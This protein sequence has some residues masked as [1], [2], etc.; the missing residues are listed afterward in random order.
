MKTLIL[1]VVC[2]FLVSCGGGTT[3]LL[4][5]GTRLNWDGSVASS[6]IRVRVF[7]LRSGAAL[8]AA[9]P[10]LIDGDARAI[11]G[12]D[13]VGEPKEVELSAP[14][15]TERE[16]GYRVRFQEGDLHPET[17]VIGVVGCFTSPTDDKWKATLKVEALNDYYF[18]FSYKE[19]KAIRR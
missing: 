12:D 2:S 8:K 14:E 17:K 15:G 10:E 5:S 13:L 1:G 7:Q 9:G 6:S 11:L 3:V 18:G 16:H 4:R 19:V